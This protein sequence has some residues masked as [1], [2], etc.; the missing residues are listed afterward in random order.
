[1]RHRV[2]NGKWFEELLLDGVIKEE[3]EWRDGTDIDAQMGIARD[4][5][6][7]LVQA[8]RG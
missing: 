6:T 4:P 5:K 7:Q 8:V 3:R 2:E 1:M